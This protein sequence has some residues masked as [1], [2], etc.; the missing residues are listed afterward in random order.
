MNAASTTIPP[1]PLTPINSLKAGTSQ[2]TILPKLQRIP[3]TGDSPQLDSSKIVTSESELPR[4]TPR[5]G[6]LS[7]TPKYVRVSEHTEGKGLVG[8]VTTWFPPS[9]TI[10]VGSN[11]L[12]QAQVGPVSSRR[13]QFVEFLGD[14]K[15]VII[16]KH[17]ILS[18]SPT[19]A[20]SPLEE[21]VNIPDD[22][23]ISDNANIESGPSAP[24]S[25]SLGPEN[26]EIEAQQVKI[27]ESPLRDTNLPFSL[28]FP[29]LLQKEAEDNE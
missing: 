29:Q 13:P 6:I 20:G 19:I 14:K 28:D 4:L 22:T 2:S 8:G 16:P 11:Q 9:S 7:T 15:F 23:M 1:P 5:P 27:E 21:S 10:Q 24:D 17:S 3:R 18:V 26:L 12:K 25:A